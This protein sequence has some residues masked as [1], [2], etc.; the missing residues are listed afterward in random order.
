LTVAIGDRQ[1][2]ITELVSLVLNEKGRTDI[3]FDWLIN[4][5]TKECFG[6]N[7]ECI[8][9]IFNSLKGDRN[10]SHAKRT[11]RLDCDAFFGGKYNFLFEFDEFQHFSSARLKTFE[12]YP[13]DIKLNYSIDRWKKQCEISKEKADN[14]RKGKAT[15]DFNFH[16]GRTAQRAYL[17]C[18][19]DILPEMH[20]LQPTIRI[21]EFEVSDI[22]SKNHDSC[23]RIE[24]LLYEK[25][26]YGRASLD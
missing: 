5:H 6:A 2:L 26:S 13:T 7:Y 23:K 12:D 4:K 9:R 1:R 8:D 18:F 10:A 25:M 17:D 16:G 21:S 14:Y 20:G 19:R 24:K 22:F 3:S 11:M 15:A